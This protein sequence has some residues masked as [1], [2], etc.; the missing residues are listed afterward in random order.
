MPPARLTCI[1]PPSAWNYLNRCRACPG[2]RRSKVIGDAPSSRHQSKLMSGHLCSPALC[3]RLGAKSVRLQSP[4][5]HLGS[6]RAAG[7]QTHPGLRGLSQRELQSE[8]AGP[9]PSQEGLQRE[10]EQAGQGAEVCGGFRGVFQGE[11][12]RAPHGEGQKRRTEAEKGGRGRAASCCR[13]PASS[14]V[15][16]GGGLCCEVWRRLGAGGSPWG[17]AGLGR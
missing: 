8:E 6:E 12:V 16:P 17:P 2:R 13:G 5:G 11:G 3:W 9:P 7:P 14:K 15:S 1:R 10:V 4:D